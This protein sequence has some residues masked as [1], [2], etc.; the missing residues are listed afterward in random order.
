MKSCGRCAG[1]IEEGDLRCA[2]CALPVPIH[3][4]AERQTRA[5]VLRCTECNAA[6]AFVP[7][8]KAP[9]CGFCGATMT[10]EQPVDPIEAAQLRIPFSVDRA[11]A[12]AGLRGWLGRRGFFAP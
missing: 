7:D 5:Q 10:I 3:A 9:R 4:Q 12:E 6:V 11:E 8:A 1:E 2:I